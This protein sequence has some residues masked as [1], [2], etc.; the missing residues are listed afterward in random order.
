M[1]RD[2]IIIVEPRTKKVIEV[3]RK[4]GGR[5]ASAKSSGARLKLSAT[6][7]ERI[8]SR[9]HDRRGARL[10]LTLEMGAAVP[11]T[12]E[13]APFPDEIFADDPELRDYEY[14]VTEDEIVLVAP[15]TR[16]VVEIIR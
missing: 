7:R 6:Q 1:V 15:E 14:F 9:L 8:R 13:L 11:D 12:V 16:E 5:A 3:I 4:G 2:E 10:D